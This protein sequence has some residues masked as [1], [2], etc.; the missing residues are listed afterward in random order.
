MQKLATAAETAAETQQA[1][2]NVVTDKDLREAAE[3]AVAWAAPF[4]EEA[5]LAAAEAE[6]A[7]AVAAAYRE[8]ADAA[9]A[10]FAAYRKAADKA[11]EVPPLH[12]P[13]PPRLPFPPSHSHSRVWQP[14]LR[15][16]RPRTFIKPPKFG[17]C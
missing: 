10:E 6:A 14:P 13:C 16:C 12:S 7:K 2:T 17:Q 5:K 15:T 1:G 11:A 8:A 3:D 9:A 4:A